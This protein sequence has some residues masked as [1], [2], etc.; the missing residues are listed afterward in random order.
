M[1][2]KLLYYKDKDG[3]EVE[4]SCRFCRV[5]WKAQTTTKGV[6]GGWTGFLESTVK[7]HAEQCRDRTP[8][9][10]HKSNMRWR[11]QYERNEKQGLSRR[12]TVI[13][14]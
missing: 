2:D 3:H 10:R 13:F 14:P 1:S 5:R 7:A 11:K 12:S 4:Y 9:E 6:Q 8:E